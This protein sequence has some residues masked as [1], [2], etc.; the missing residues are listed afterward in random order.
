M[1]CW[2][3]RRIVGDTQHRAGA[4]DGDLERVGAVAE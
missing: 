2:A 3:L 4:V 1:R